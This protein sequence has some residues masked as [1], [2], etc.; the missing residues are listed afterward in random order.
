ME[1]YINE[2]NYYIEVQEESGNLI[3]ESI[4]SANHDQLLSQLVIDD[5]NLEND[6]YEESANENEF[7]LI[8]FRNEINKRIKG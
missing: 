1:M 5:L 2:F 3:Q 8:Y 7:L 4:P 6:E